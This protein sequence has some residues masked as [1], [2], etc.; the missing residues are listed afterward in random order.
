MIH[1]ERLLKPI[2]RTNGQVT[3]E[4][5]QKKRKEEEEEEEEEEE[6]KNQNLICFVL[7]SWKGVHQMLLP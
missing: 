1:D 2:N 6:A 5:K 7:L 4:Q 3:G